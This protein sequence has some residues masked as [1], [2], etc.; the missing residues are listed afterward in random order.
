MEI[1]FYRFIKTSQVWFNKNPKI[2]IDK[3]SVFDIIEFR[4]SKFNFQNSLS[5]FVN[6]IINLNREIDEIFLSFDKG[7]KYEIRRAEKEGITCHTIDLNSE[8]ANQYFDYYYKFSESRKLQTINKESLYKYLKVGAL[9]LTAS[10][11][12]DNILQIHMY[13]KSNEEMILLASFPT[14]SVKVS[15]SFIGFAN[16]YLHWFDIKL[17]KSKLLSIYNLG[18]IGNGNLDDKKNAIIKFKEEMSP[19]RVT[20]FQGLIANTWKGKIFIILKK[21]YETI[22]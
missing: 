14:N 1:K 10:K 4:E 21:C 7:F 20:Y 22:K 18:G 17:G 6:G 13:I 12:E 15:N 19:E 11:F 2:D 9:L 5:P 3:A 8:N 16:R